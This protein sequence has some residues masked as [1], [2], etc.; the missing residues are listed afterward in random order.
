[1]RNSLC[2]ALEVEKNYIKN[3]IKLETESMVGRSE[4]PSWR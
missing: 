1:M 4:V 2:P 3:F